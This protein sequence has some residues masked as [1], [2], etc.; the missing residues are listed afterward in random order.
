ME[1]VF[2]TAL[3][4]GDEDAMTL[5]IVNFDPVKL[6]DLPITDVTTVDSIELR[7]QLSVFSLPFRF[8]LTENK[9][10]K[11]K[12]KFTLSYVK[13]KQKQ[14]INDGS[15]DLK[16]DDILS[17]NVTYQ[18]S[19]FL[20]SNWT[21]SASLGN[22]L[23][24]YKN[25]YNYSSDLAPFKAQLDGEYYNIRSNALLFEPAIQAEY[26]RP[27]KWGNWVYRSRFS[28]FYGWTF[29]GNEAVRGANPSGWEWYNGV[30]G[31]FDLHTDSF[32]AETFYL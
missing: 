13:Q 26:N 3:M 20:T 19:W 9:D 27:Q 5:G 1:S 25:T 17:V 2:A 7:N 30:K 14:V 24:T 22:H 29:A 12:L 10:F 21:A 23:M 32:G 15:A 28:T 31:Y 18:R 8:K 16:R 11:D 6:L 4:L